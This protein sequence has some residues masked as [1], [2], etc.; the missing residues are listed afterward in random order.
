MSDLNAFTFTGRLTKAAE[1]KSTNSG[2]YL[3]NLSIA[4]DNSYKGANG[5]VED[6]CFI[7]CTAWAGLAEVISKHTD[8]GHRVGISGGLRQAKWDDREGKTHY[9]HYV[10]IKE[11]TFLQ[12]RTEKSGDTV[13]DEFNGEYTEPFNEDIPF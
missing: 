2:K 13:K 7:E 10:I 3:C 8:K 11:F 9:K 6:T 12:P 5:K 4:I 1:L